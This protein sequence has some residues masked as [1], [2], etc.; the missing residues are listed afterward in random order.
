LWALPS[1]D[2]AFSAAQNHFDDYVA[3]HMNLTNFIHGTANF[4]TWHRYLIYLWEQKLRTQCGY[5]GYLPVRFVSTCLSTPSW[6]IMYGTDSPDSYSTGT[7]SNTRTI[8]PSR[9]S[10]TAVTPAWAAM[11][12]TLRTTAVSSAPGASGCRQAKEA[13]A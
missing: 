4:L 3:V 12:S 13:A 11:A 8:S 7:G 10:S 5:Q 9:P 2:P 1:V 6:H